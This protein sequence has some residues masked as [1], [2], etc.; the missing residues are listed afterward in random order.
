[1]KKTDNLEQATLN[2]LG[3]GLSLILSSSAVKIFLI[4]LVITTFGLFAF[5]FRV[6]PMF[7]FVLF[8]LIVI[9]LFGYLFIMLPKR[10][11]LFQ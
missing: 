1:M 7:P 10:P 11:E 9:A 4:A 3:Q 2:L 6:N 5:S 8:A